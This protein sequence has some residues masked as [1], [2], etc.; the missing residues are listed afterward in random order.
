[1]K[2]IRTPQIRGVALAL[3]ATLLLVSCAYQ[4]R[5][6]TGAHYVHIKDLSWMIGEWTDTRENK[7]IT[8]VCRWSQERNF[9]TRTFE[10]VEDHQTTI[11]G[12]EV[13]GWDPFEKRIRSWTF[14]SR[15]G[16]ASSVW[17]LEGDQWK[18]QTLEDM[19]P[20]EPAARHA[21][22][23]ELDWM[24]GAWVDAGGDERV[25]SAW[26]W[27]DSKAFLIQHFKVFADG[28]PVQE[29]LGIVGWDAQQESLRH[30]MFDTDAGFAE[31]IGFG[32]EDE[33]QMRNQYVL[34]DGQLASAVVI[35]RKI[36]DNR[37]TWRRI[38]QEVDGELLPDMDEI[39]VVRQTPV[40]DPE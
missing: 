5:M 33:W 36:D 21:A 16:F 35:Y 30:W 31:G 9:I 3:T 39:T 17:T 22:L 12:T 11:K 19:A 26:Q 8:N 37:F 24:V 28:K 6:S 40:N 2:T 27:S 4:T 7:T 13:I 20:S 25:E 1:M 10:V 14:D 18:T 38:A 29:G 23:S 15:G 32:H 34:P